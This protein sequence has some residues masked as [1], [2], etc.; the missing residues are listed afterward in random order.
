MFQR[1]R[2]LKICDLQFFFFFFFLRKCDLQFWTYVS[3]IILFW[4]NHQWNN[5]FSGPLKT[6]VP[7]TC[8]PFNLVQSS[9]KPFNSLQQKKMKPFNSHWQWIGRFWTS[10]AT[11]RPFTYGPILSVK[12]F[13][14]EKLVLKI[15]TAQLCKL[16]LFKYLS[17]SE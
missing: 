17:V 8:I 15:E 14:F 13:Y 1:C 10:G 16:L 2:R 12:I 9:M 11:S 5:N 6:K 3:L 7:Y 4:F